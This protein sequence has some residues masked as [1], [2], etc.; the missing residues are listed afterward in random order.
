MGE[1]TPGGANTQYQDFSGGDPMIRVK[2]PVGLL[3]DRA[4]TASAKVVWMALS[5]FE[6]EG[7]GAR[8]AVTQLA[9]FTGL[10]RPT[11][12]KALADL[13]AA[14]WYQSPQ[15]QGSLM[16]TADPSSTA[17]SPD[18]ARTSSLDSSG[19]STQVSN[20]AYAQS[21]DNQLT[22]QRFA[23]IPKQLLEDDALNPQAIVMYGVL[24]ATPEYHRRSGR[25]THKLLAELTGRQVKVIRRSVNQLIQRGWLQVIRKN[26][27]HPF[28]F[29][30][31]NPVHE[32]CMAELDMVKRRL[33]RAE[34]LGE[35]LM[36]EFLT[37]IV[38]SKEF[39]D[40][41]SPGYLVN[42]FTGERME[43]D[44][45]YPGRVAFEFNG[46]QHYRTTDFAT[47]QEVEKQRA[48]DRIKAGICEDH[49]IP[50]VVIRAEDL[51]LQTMVEKVRPYLPLR[52]LRNS[53]PLVRYLEMRSK[54]YRQSILRGEAVA[55]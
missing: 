45:Y 19:A 55:Q 29:T 46:P 18:S 20:Q 47:A 33:K 42:P 5:L 4:L 32:E 54:Q 41:A 30:V 27:L 6:V 21:G 24:Q 12:R 11:V 40:N 37:L 26:R 49:G 28:A 34:F 16:N 8:P 2:V 53:E 10:S 25:V 3:L 13:G 36:K 7:D 14:R 23:A 38:D 22:I 17:N 9:S 50:L 48:R 51:T 43:L 44:R 31:R 15:T 35:A 52:N 39:E 1:G